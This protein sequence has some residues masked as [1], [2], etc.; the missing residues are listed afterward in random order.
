[1]DFQHRLLTDVNSID[2]ESNIVN[3]DFSKLMLT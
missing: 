2:I 1:M 3:I